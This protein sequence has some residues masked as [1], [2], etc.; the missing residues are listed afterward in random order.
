MCLCPTLNRRP[1]W[2]SQNFSV[3]ATEPSA[4]S[5][6]KAHRHKPKRIVTSQSASSQ[7]KAHRPSQSA[8]SQAKAHRHKPKRIVSPEELAAVPRLTAV[9]VAAGGYRQPRKPRSVDPTPRPGLALAGGGRRVCHGAPATSAPVDHALRGAGRCVRPV[10]ALPVA[11]HGT[12]P[13]M[14]GH[15]GAA[16][17]AGGPASRTLQ[18]PRRR[19]RMASTRPP[20]TYSP[21]AR[22]GR[23]GGGSG[24]V[25]AI[26]NGWPGPVSVPGERA[27]P[28]VVCGRGRNPTF[29]PLPRHGPPASGCKDLLAL[30]PQLALITAFW[31]TA[32]LFH[33]RDAFRAGD[34]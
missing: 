20:G 30:L 15:D 29:S 27:A 10:L 34:V 21:S 12:S 7:A 4:S 31:E 26:D 14:V 28:R 13:A 23:R 11:R 6:A 3:Y 5:Q 24:G 25:A 9:T 2:T 22:A 8:S 17:Q 19:Q 33:L 16:R 18:R 32:V 1:H